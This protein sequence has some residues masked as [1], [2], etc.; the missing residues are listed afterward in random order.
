MKVIIT[1]ASGFLGRNLLQRLE[2]AGYEYTALSSKD[3]DLTKQGSLD[4]FNSD[5]YDRIYHLA[6]WTEA[7]DFCLH[8][9]G[10][11]WVINQLINT[12]VLQWWS[13]HQPQAKLISIGTSCSYACEDNLVE[14]RYLY[15]EPFKDLYAYAMTKRMLLVG[16]K[17]LQKQ[18]GLRYLTVIP[19]T[20]YGPGYHTH[21]KQMHFIF[22]LI[23][24]V[25][26]HKNFSKDIIL[27]GDGYQRR[28]V[29]YVNDFTD[30]LLL[31]DQKVENDVVNVGMGKDYSIR[32]FARMICEIVGV[33]P[34]LIVYDTSKY[35]GAKSKILNNVKLDLLLPDRKTTSLGEGLAAT[36]AW[37]ERDMFD[38]GP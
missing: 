8:H 29:V 31:L 12:H 7:G 1:G 16:Q 24:K 5:K 21:G 33:D 18:Y 36:I 28:E 11:Q 27:W 6:S 4:R 34:E 3:A 19:S 15:G 38:A 14:E 10:E 35:V 25:L 26:E 23:R 2:G 30:A 9:P 37:M 32:D 13:Q 17:A 20:L 22:D